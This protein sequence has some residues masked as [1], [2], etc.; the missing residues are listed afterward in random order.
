MST[1]FSRI[2]QA[3]TAKRG[4][5]MK[6]LLLSALF[7]FAFAPAVEADVKTGAQAFRAGDYAA[8]L[9]EFSAAAEKGDSNAQHALGLMYAQGVGVPRDR[10]IAAEWFRKAAE[11]GH[12]QSQ[13]NLAVSY[14]TGIG[15]ARDHAQAADWFRKAAEQG[16]ARAQNNLGHM[17]AAGTG[18]SQDYA[19]A[20][21]WYRRA[22]G[23]GNIHAAVNLANSYRLGRGVPQD[24][25]LA[26]ELYARV[27]DSLKTRDPLRLW[28]VGTTGK[29]L[30]YNEAT[31]AGPA[32]PRTRPWAQPAGRTTEGRRRPPSLG[33]APEYLA[34]ATTQETSAAEAAASKGFVVQLGAFEDPG[35]AFDR[36]EQLGRT[37]PQ[38]LADPAFD[39]S[40]QVN[41]VDSGAGKG[42]I[43]RVEAG[44]FDEKGK[45]EAFCEQLKSRDIDC[46]LVEPQAGG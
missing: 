41:R 25:A 44:P 14:L 43:Y 28:L 19:E 20:V 24:R 3:P 11:Q 46:F 15:V 18:V 9:R 17:Y 2:Y 35:N 16:D 29:V 30:A 42:V 37:L 31:G 36:W 40:L 26:S 6:R 1:M 4:P 34:P 8:A 33:V 38:L 21:V 23:A 45:A 7:L 32:P 39:L 22:A 5:K 10:T 27:F 13:H 12:P